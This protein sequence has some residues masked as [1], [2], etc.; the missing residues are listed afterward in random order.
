MIKSVIE[1]IKEVNKMIDI[2]SKDESTLTLEQYQHRRD[3]LISELEMNIESIL[4]FDNWKDWK[5]Y[6]YM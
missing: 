6:I 4:D 3:K 1:E 5:N 2:H